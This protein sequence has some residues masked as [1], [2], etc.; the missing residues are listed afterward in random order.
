M[1]SFSSQQYPTT[2]TPH[3]HSSRAVRTLNNPVIQALARARIQPVES[4]PAH[5]ALPIKI[6]QK[7]IHL[8]L[9][10]QFRGRHLRDPELRNAMLALQILI[11]AD[12]TLEVLEIIS[13]AVVM[14][15]EDVDGA[16]LGLAF[17]EEVA[18]VV[19]A[20]G[21]VV[22]VVRRSG[23]DEFDGAGFL[24]F[25]VGHPVGDA[26][27]DVHLGSAFVGRHVR[28]VEAHEIRVAGGVAVPEA[29]VRVNGAQEH[30][31]ELDVEGSGCVARCR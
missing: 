27:I 24:G 19:D 22:E 10:R 12:C 28:L 3:A 20:H 11:F 17:V 6:R 4:V 25:H 8:V 16:S 9:C 14:E 7:R 18:H 2:P 29:G 5:S 21:R 23:G 31:D 30:G 13:L 1:H 15:G 26:G